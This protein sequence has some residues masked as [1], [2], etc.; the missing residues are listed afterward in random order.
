MEV[1]PETLA[2]PVPRQPAVA[3]IKAERPAVAPVAP[4]APAP[5]VPVLTP[6]LAAPEE[7]AFEI[8]DDM[9]ES[10][11]RAEARDRGEVVVPVPKTESEE[12][13]DTKPLPPLD[14]M[15]ER[16]PAEVRD[17]LEELFRAKFVAVRRVPAKALKS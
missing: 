13:V 17:V 11:F 5:A 2:E 9:A 7:P 8:V 4:T 6:A 15:V 10:A 3:P 16:I 12:S 1:R 14:K